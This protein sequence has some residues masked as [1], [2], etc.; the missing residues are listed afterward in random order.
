[1]EHTVKKSEHMTIKVLH[2]VSGVYRCLLTEGCEWG[3]TTT[4][5]EYEVLAGP[6]FTLVFTM[7]ALPLGMLA[8]STR[9]NRKMTIAVCVVL[10]SAMTL[11]SSFTHSFWQLLLTRIGLGIL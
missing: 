5:I 10:W 11:A 9:V 7:V 2:V 3:H 1:M 8:G 4:G 6:A